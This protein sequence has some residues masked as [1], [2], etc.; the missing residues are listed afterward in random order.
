MLMNTTLN[1]KKV[2]SD[3][4]D[5]QLLCR[6]TVLTAFFHST[7]TYIRVV[8]QQPQRYNN[9]VLGI[10]SRWTWMTRW[11]LCTFLHFYILSL[12]SSALPTLYRNCCTTISLGWN[13]VLSH[14]KIQD[15]FKLILWH[16]TTGHLHMSLFDSWTEHNMLMKHEHVIKYVK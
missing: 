15:A 16:R 13:K 7:V 2:Q 12:Q 4:E 9:N 11:T 6:T 14:L 10:F 5:V 1:K 3:T 8:N